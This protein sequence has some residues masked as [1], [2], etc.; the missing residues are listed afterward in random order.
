MTLL[1]WSGASGP[2]PDNVVCPT[3]V[4]SAAALDPA[5]IDAILARQALL[6]VPC[7]FD[8]PEEEAAWRLLPRFT[9]DNECCVFLAHLLSPELQPG[10]T[11]NELI[12]KRHE[13]MLA[14][15]ADDVLMNPKPEPDALRRTIFLAR[16]VWQLNVRRM[17]LMLEAEA[18][19][20]SKEEMRQLESQHRRL[21]WD[22]IPRALMPNFR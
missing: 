20:V 19:P 13:A 8:P 6:V 2:K 7:T 22:S 12:M 18:E 15:G 4:G 3:Q 11:E 21:L 10:R 14:T 16:S 17:Q 9:Q 1:P 5:Q